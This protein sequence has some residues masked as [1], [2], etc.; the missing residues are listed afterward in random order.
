MANHLLG[1]RTGEPQ[2]LPSKGQIGHPVVGARHAA[3]LGHDLEAAVQ[4][5]RMDF[6][7]AL[8]DGFGKGQFAHRFAF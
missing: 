2:P 7:A 3:S 1:Q 5:K 8:V 4:E 6:D